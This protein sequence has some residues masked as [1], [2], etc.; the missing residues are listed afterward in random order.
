[1][2]KYCPLHIS[3]AAFHQDDTDDLIKL[4]NAAGKIGHDNLESLELAWGSGGNSPGIWI[5]L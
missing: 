4:L 5:H 1:M 3:K 2:K